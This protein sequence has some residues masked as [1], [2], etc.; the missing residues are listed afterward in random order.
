MRKFA[1]YISM[2]ISMI[3]ILT[4]CGNNKID[5]DNNQ[6]ENIT[7]SFSTFYEE[8]AEADAYKEIIEAYEAAHKNVK[9]KFIPG[10][11]NY[12]EN[13]KNS[14]SQGKGPDI[15]GLQRSNMLYYVNEGYIKDISELIESG[16]FRDKYFGVST[17][18]GKYNGKYYGIGD[19]PRPILWYY[20]IDMFKKAGV[21]EP[22]NLEELISVCNKLKKYT[23]FPIMIGAKDP[24]VVNTV[25]G[26][27]TAQTVDT[28]SLSKA[29]SLSNKQE[30]IS[31]Q[32]ISD[33][34]D[35]LGKLVKQ[36]AIND[37]VLDYDYAASVDAFVKGNA[38]IL[39][40]GSWA[41]E[42]IEE[43]KPKEFN[44]KAFDNE[45]LFV[46]NPKS[47]YSATAVQV[48][49]INA[50]SK[51]IKQCEEFIKYL[52][53][54]E[55][56]KIF[57][58]KNGTSS[59]KSANSKGQLAKYL[60]ATDENSTMYIDNVNSKVMDVTSKRLQQLIKGKIKSSEVW[61]LIIDEYIPQNN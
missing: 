56:Q 58:E 4:S 22:K 33:A 7:L 49:T 12:D 11:T 3:L 46:E 52:F 32:G 10:A 25:F 15:I 41:E 29:F 20:N 1:L 42:R 34:V 9:I 57:A 38:A 43:V 27:I 5:R 31:L 24:W 16:G 6:D 39:P 53:S 45:L 36:G 30:L 37:D 19:M 8:G 17:G 13:I 18:Y 50:K 14:L 61:K 2:L 44:Y 59:L 48:I 35:I 54:E 28:N 21:E 55:A 26:M 47:K 23:K 51:Y 40:M 60:E